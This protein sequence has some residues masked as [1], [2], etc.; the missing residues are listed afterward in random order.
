M[1]T[2]SS[3]PANSNKPKA[4][5]V[6]DFVMAHP[7]RVLVGGAVIGIGGYFLYKLGR[8]IFTKARKSSTEKKLDDSLEVRQATILRNAMNPSGVSWLMSFDRTNEDKIFETAKNIVKLDDVM[9]AYKKLYDDDLLKDLQSELDTEE[10]QKF[11]TLISSNPSKTG[12]A[13]TSFAKK[14]QLVVAKK[15]VYVRSTPDASYHEAFYESSS[16]NNIL[17]QAKAGDFIGYATGKQEYDSKND[18]KFIQA[19]YVVKKEGLPAAFKQY[20]GKSFTM[21]VSSSKDY[22]DIFD[23]YQPMFDQYPKTKEI[24]AYKKPLNYYSSGV[25]GFPSKAVISIANT[26]VLDEKMQVYCRVEKQ[27]LLGEFTG[28]LNAGNTTYVRFRTVDNTERWADA[29]TVKIFES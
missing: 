8:K 4:E 27:V 19:G 6:L 7:G 23:F 20:A 22:V 29:R 11:L 9:S 28:C 18:V 24:V 10:Y 15:E 21:W 5:Q 14:N 26:S 2:Q 3:K 12:A 17:F 25:K 1:N 16:G 13:A